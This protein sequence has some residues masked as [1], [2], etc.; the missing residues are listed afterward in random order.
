MYGKICSKS[1]FVL[2]LATISLSLPAES[3][4]QRKAKARHPRH[5]TGIVR[6][7]AGYRTI[8]T[9]G[10]NYYYYRGVYYM[11]GPFGF[12]VVRGPVG[13]RVA[14]L[15]AGNI[16]MYAGS[17]VYY[18]CY[19][20]YYRYDPLERVYIVVEPPLKEV[21]ADETGLD[22]VKLIDGTT[23]RGIYIG[24]TAEKIQFEVNGEVRE[25]PVADI[26][27]MNFAPPRAT[28]QPPPV[29]GSGVIPAGKRLLVRINDL[30][31]TGQVQIGNR[32]SATVVSPV[33][34]DGNLIIPANTKVLGRVAE[35]REGR[36]I[37]GNA[38]L[39]LKLTDISVNG[40]LIPIVSDRCGWMVQDSGTLVK[41]G[42]G[43]AIGGII[44]GIEGAV[45]GAVVGGVVAL[46]TPGK[47]IKIPPGTLMEFRIM[48]QVK[49]NE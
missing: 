15:P 29:P 36:R 31:V 32:F 3:F 42:A 18:Y 30:L 12:V 22:E 26:V 4:A 44:E 21:S 39:L 41:I 6:P 23:L 34:V 24:G 43:A 33:T 37:A 46:L 2:L 16:S 17:G 20:T 14:V 49:V 47:Q 38:K 48:E 10:R 8:V 5:P 35:A 13:A 19:G 1:L 27:S 11:R 25:I 28:A 9:H 45:K 7:P 40:Q